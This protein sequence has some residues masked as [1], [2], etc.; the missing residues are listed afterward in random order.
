MKYERFIEENLKIIDK[1]RKEVDFVLNPVQRAYNTKMGKR[2]IILKARQQGFSSFILGR[3]SADFI[4]KENSYSVVVADNTDNA[5][6]LLERVKFF[7][8]SY[9]EKNNFKIPLKYNSKYE[10]H[11]EYNN[12]KYI[13]GT[14][15]NNEVARSKTITNLH[16]SE[17][18]FYPHFDKILASAAQAVVPD[19]YIVI[20]T[21]AH[22]FNKFRDFWIESE[23]GQTGYNP[24]FF[25]ASEF[26]SPEFLAQKRKEL[27]RQYPQEYPET[28]EEAFLTTGECFFDLE[29]LKSHLGNAKE[30]FAKSL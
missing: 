6:G 3:F 28:P 30:D 10:L 13:I 24:M 25:N 23:R 22:G 4:L 19:G 1:N 7:L 15:E 18:A 5:I 21:T 14:A 29:A 16:L 27:G 2:D 12:A 8:K 9:E 26:Y 17:A 11:N 20:E